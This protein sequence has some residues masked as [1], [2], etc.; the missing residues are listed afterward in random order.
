MAFSVRNTKRIFKIHFYTICQYSSYVWNAVHQPVNPFN[1]IP[2][3][4]F[5]TSEGKKQK[6]KFKKQNTK[7]EKLGTSVSLNDNKN[8]TKYLK[9]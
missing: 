4:R 7:T 5:K 3:T 6:L 2:K 1:T 9:F 8:K